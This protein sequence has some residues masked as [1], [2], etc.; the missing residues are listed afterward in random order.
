MFSLI[1]ASVLM[2]PTQLCS[3]CLERN[4]EIS[5][6]QSDV[7]VLMKQLRASNGRLVTL[8]SQLRFAR[9]VAI[10]LMQVPYEKRDDTWMRNFREVMSL[11]GQLSAE[12]EIERMNQ[13]RIA[14]ELSAAKDKI[15]RLQFLNYVCP[16]CS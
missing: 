2:M 7:N 16:V 4:D 15:R 8:E 6:L 3:D 1:V 13:A 14:R 10:S 9:I 11:M 5:S 12:V